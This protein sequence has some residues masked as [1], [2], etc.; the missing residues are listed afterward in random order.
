MQLKHMYSVPIG[1][2]VPNDRCMQ[3][4]EYPRDDRPISPHGE[5]TDQLLSFPVYYSGRQQKF[6]HAQRTII[7]IN[8]F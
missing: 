7:I 5:S 4:T 8:G 6:S 3:H 2:I 1:K